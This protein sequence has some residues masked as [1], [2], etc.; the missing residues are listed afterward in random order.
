[1][2]QGAAG[3]R[4]STLQPAPSDDE[5]VTEPPW[6]SAMRCTI[7]S[8]NPEPGTVVAHADDDLAAGAP[9]LHLDRGAWGVPQRVLD[10]IV[11]RHAQLVLIAPL[12]FALSKTRG[13]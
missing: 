2:A 10:E 1:M 11:E 8:P 6:R 9:D 7:A 12:G 5:S 13:P 4:S 3:M